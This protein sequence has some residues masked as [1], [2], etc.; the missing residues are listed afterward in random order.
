MILR[1]FPDL[2]PRP[3]SPALAAFRSEFFTR[4]GRENVL[5]CGQTRSARYLPFM[6]T[7]SIKMAWNGAH[8]F[9]VGN[10][11]LSVDD[12][13]YL[14]L[15]E[16]NTYGSEVASRE[17][18]GAQ[19]L[20]FRRGMAAEVFGALTQKGLQ[21]LD[22]GAET[23]RRPLEFAEHLR[24]HDSV[25]TPLLR[26]IRDQIDAG[27]EDALWYDE[28]MQALL[29]RMIESENG[30]RRHLRQLGEEGPAVRREL[31][32]RIGWAADFMLSGYADPLSLDE[33]AAAARLSKFHLVRLFKRVY[34][35]TPH[36][37]LTHKRVT[38]A[39]RL[40]MNTDLQVNDIAERSGFGSRQ[41]MFR[42]L[43]A[44]YGASARTLRA[45]AAEPRQPAGR[46]L[47]L[48]E[49]Q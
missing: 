31:A 1:E 47:E 39:R 43:R 32:R 15:N 9:L 13:S 10:R 33:I 16:G 21:M 37:F 49:I 38:V 24:P 18:I 25:V 28:Q 2:R 44:A 45:E 14:I 48:E 29:V 11:R 4:Y 7:L 19:C 20:F 34:G 27:C 40:L 17:P 22:D 12:D 3:T 46:I 36:A 5:I 23:A 30:A 42:Q 6:H 41:A 35:V 8:H 26:R